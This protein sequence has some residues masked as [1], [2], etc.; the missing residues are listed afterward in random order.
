MVHTVRAQNMLLLFFSTSLALSYLLG[1]ILSACPLAC[2]PN[3]RLDRVCSCKSPQH[4]VYVLF[5]WLGFS[6]QCFPA[7]KTLSIQG[8][9]EIPDMTSRQ[10]G[11][12]SLHLTG[13]VANSWKLPF[14]NLPSTN[15][16]TDPLE[17]FPR[18]GECQGFPSCLPRGCMYSGKG[19]FVLLLVLDLPEGWQP[20]R[21]TR[22]GGHLHVPTFHLTSLK[23]TA[24][25]V[26]KPR[27]RALHEAPENIL[28]QPVLEWERVLPSLFWSLFHSWI[29]EITQLVKT[30]PNKGSIKSEV[31]ISHWVGLLD[32]TP[33]IWW[34][35]PGYVGRS[36]FYFLFT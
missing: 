28:G 24:T 25:S 33:N 18:S 21:R 27:L 16:T 3:N 9:C 35:M 10:K 22:W 14:W 36:P 2:D 17:W 6:T 15:A 19:P 4:Y 34:G 32:R 12:N 26:N 31:N 20:Q 30:F 8:L 11:V 29:W 1:L 23:A 7:I 13:T 5:H